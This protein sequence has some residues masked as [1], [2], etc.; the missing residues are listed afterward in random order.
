MNIYESIITGLNQAIDYSQGKCPSKLSIIESDIKY[1]VGIKY[2]AEYNS[3]E[4][5]KHEGSKKP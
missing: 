4:I 1:C 2:E 3:T 5:K